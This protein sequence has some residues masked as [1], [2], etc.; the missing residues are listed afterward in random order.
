MVAKIG[1]VK[2]P[3]LSDATTTFEGKLATVSG[4]DT[5]VDGGLVLYLNFSTKFNKNSIVNT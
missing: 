4:F 3:P 2:L 1:L 5:T